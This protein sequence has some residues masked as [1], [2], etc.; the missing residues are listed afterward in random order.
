MDKF[1]NLEILRDANTDY[2]FA[3]CGYAFQ[4]K[5]IGKLQDKAGQI[6]TDASPPVITANNQ[7]HIRKNLRVVEDRLELGK[8]IYDLTQAQKSSKSTLLTKKLERLQSFRDLVCDFC[9]QIIHQMYWIDFKEDQKSNLSLTDCSNFAIQITK[10]LSDKFVK[11][12][13]DEYN[14]AKAIQEEFSKSGKF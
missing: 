5:L 2:D 13:D 12:L 9:L 6:I 4:V 10:E 1:D 3:H 7:G 11:R 8:I 14:I